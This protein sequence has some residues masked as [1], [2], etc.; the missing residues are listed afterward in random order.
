MAEF[1]RGHLSASTS[2]RPVPVVAT[3][4]TGTTIHTAIAGAALFDSMFLWATN[5][6]GASATLTLEWGATGTGNKLCDAVNIPPNGVPKLI[7]DG[8]TLNGGVLVT[9]FSSV[10]SAIN[11]TG[12]V[13][14][15]R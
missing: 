2:G 6:S 9:A 5:A 13:D 14:Q 11:L 3:A 15:I 1:S 12:Y 8:Q 4:S 7:A 10:A